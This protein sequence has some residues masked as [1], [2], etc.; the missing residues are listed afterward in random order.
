MLIEFCTS[1]DHIANIVY[2]SYSTNFG[3]VL[4]AWHGKVLCFVAFLEHY[5]TDSV[6]ARIKKS[7]PKAILT[8]SNDTPN[9]FICQPEKIL[10]IGTPFQH[11]VW[12]ALSELKP[13]E[14]ITYSTLAARIGHP[15]AV[16]ATATAVG[17]NPISYI[18][19]CHRVLP[20]SGGIG[21]YHW[22]EYIKLKI[23]KHE[24]SLP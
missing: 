3:P 1:G 20:A 4:T 23:L 21:L 13:R 5:S 12:R 17:A 24:G 10:L 22:G 19:P 2:S 16:R 8:Y 18:V 6:I 11:K 14:I 15:R 7:F 9:I